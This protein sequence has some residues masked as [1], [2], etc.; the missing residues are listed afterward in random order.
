[1]KNNAESVTTQWHRLSLF[2]QRWR[3]AKSKSIW[4]K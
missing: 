2:W 4:C 3:E 1:L